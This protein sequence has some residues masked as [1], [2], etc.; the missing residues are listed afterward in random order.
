MY[1]FFTSAIIQIDHNLRKICVFLDSTFLVVSINSC[2][3]EYEGTSEKKTFL[4]SIIARR[5][6]HRAG[7]RLYRRGIDSNGDVANFVE[8]EQIVEYD[9]AQSSFVQVIKRNI[10]R[11]CIS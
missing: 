4:W 7:T 9:G 1:P 2:T 5:S 10:K 3:F 11:T 6:C 8:T